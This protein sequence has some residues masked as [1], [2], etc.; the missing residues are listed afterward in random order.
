MLVDFYFPG[1]ENTTFSNNYYPHNYPKLKVRFFYPPRLQRGEA[2]G[3]LK[4]HLN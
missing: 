2:V 3:R 4:R 1:G